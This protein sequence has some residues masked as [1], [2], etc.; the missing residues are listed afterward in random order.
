MGFWIPG[1][2]T[3]A[4]G[5]CA[6]GWQSKTKGTVAIEGRA[7]HRLVLSESEQTY[8]SDNRYGESTVSLSNP[9][10][11][12]KPGTLKN[13]EYGLSGLSSVRAGV[14]AF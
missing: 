11:D 3:H 10:R 8:T 7:G 13:A 12:Y 9:D 6:P 5:K 1:A 2:Q 4:V 14:P